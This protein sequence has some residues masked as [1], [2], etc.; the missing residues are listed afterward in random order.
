[1][2][3]DAEPDITMPEPAEALASAHG[4]LATPA[5][6][7]RHLIHRLGFTYGKIADRNGATAPAGA[8]RALRVVPQADA[9]DAPR[10]T[11]AGFVDGKED[12]KMPPWGV[13][14]THAV[15]PKMTRPR[16]RSARAATG[17]RRAL[18]PLAHTDLHRASAR[19]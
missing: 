2:Y 10:A 19:R 15:T 7:S 4:V 6:L 14:P 1:M 13:F 5:M 18:R 11:P 8:R 3:V 17:S 12:R 16:G 9:E